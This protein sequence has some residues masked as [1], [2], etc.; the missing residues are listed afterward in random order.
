MIVPAAMNVEA[1]LDSLKQQP[2]PESFAPDCRKELQ[3]AGDERFRQ[4]GL[5]PPSDEFVRG[6]V[7]ALFVVRDML[8][9]TPD[10]QRVF[11]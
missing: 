7:F 10:P 5:A 3:A 8:P 6:F 11:G 2:M 9:L 4:A 1:T